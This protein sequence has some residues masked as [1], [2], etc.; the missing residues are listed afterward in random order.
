MKHMVL[1]IY[2][3]K[4]EAYNRPFFTPT[5]GAAERAISDE[6]NRE[7]SEMNKHPEDY[8]LHH[9]GTWDDTDGTFENNDKARLICQAANLKQ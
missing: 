7:G 2:D 1:A 6:V 3:M 9:L 8:S 5:I 4:L